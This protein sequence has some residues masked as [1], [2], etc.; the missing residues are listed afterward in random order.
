M[1]M[2]LTSFLSLCVISCAS[3]NVMSTSDKLSYERFKTIKNLNH[4][5]ESFANILVKGDPLLLG[6]ENLELWQLKNSGST[7]LAEFYITPKTGEIL[8][9][10]FYPGYKDK[11]N[12]LEYLLKNEFKNSNFKKIPVKCRHFD[13]VVY[14]DENERILL[15][16]EDKE[17][18]RVDAVSISTPKMVK[19]RIDENSKRKCF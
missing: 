10:N 4:L 5:K 12:K 8:E 14:A 17:K 3:G 9:R 15:I 13:E 1:K 18:A 16:T 2:I 19:F 11:Q 7:V 6:T